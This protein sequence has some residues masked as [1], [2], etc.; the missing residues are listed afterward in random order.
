MDDERSEHVDQRAEGSEPSA[1]PA[2][3]MLVVPIGSAEPMGQVRLRLTV[4]EATSSAGRHSWSLGSRI[5]TGISRRVWRWYT[6]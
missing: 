6:S 5:T 3:L 4:D 2:L 1:L